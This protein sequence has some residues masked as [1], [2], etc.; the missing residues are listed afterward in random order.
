MNNLNLTKSILLFLIGCTIIACNPEEPDNG[1]GQSLMDIN[2]S[3]TPYAVEVPSEF[4]AIELPDD[5]DLIIEKIELGQHL[6]FDPILSADSTMA[7]ASCHIP[8]KGFTDGLAVSTGIDGISGDKSSMSLVNSAYYNTGLFW[9]GRI[10]SLEEQALLPVED[11]IEMHNNWPDLMDKLM[12]HDLY[13][14]LFRKAFGIDYTGE[15][16]KEMAA[17]ALA[18]YQR[19]IIS[20]NSKFDR[21]LRNEG[22]LT[23]EELEG[24]LMF[25]EKDDDLPDAG[26]W[27]CHSAPLLTNNSFRNNG[28]EEV[29]NRDDYADF[30]FGN[31]TGF[32]V[33]NGKF[34]VPTLRNIALTAPYMHDGQFETLEEVI[35]HYD[36]GGLPSPNKDFELLNLGLTDQQKLNLKLF[37]LTLTDTSYLDNQYV[38]NPFN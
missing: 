35:E 11:P 38:R 32:P 12:E 21:F 36:K 30:G 22:G 6:F 10:G 19:I 24:S 34:R 25:F 2:Y 18:Q 4:P 33:D 14:T 37:L 28:L 31:I 5:N 27:H 8:E 15:M 20:G 13:P 26:C 17:K 9:D 23:D 1:L 16:T 7:C 29:E 3:P